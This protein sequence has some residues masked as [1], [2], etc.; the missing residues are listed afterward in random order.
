MYV[1][2]YVCMYVSMYVCMCLCMYICVYV[3]IYVSMY[4]CMYA[5][6]CEKQFCTLFLHMYMY[7]MH[8]CIH[9]CSSQNSCDRMCMNVYIYDAFILATPWLY[10]CMYASR[11]ECMYVC[12]QACLHV[13]C[14]MYHVRITYVHA[15]IH[16]CME[17][18]QIKIS[19]NL[20]LYMHT[21]Y[22][23]ICI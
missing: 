2:M 23:H 9:A 5:C 18:V 22:A 15:Y 17:I 7:T 13:T 14:P 10:A 6:I 16:V 3:C 8:E 19:S 20:S 1:S 21:S 11:C 4:V 12:R